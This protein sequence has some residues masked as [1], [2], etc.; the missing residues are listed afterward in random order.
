MATVT[1]VLRKDRMNKN[2]EAPLNFYIIRHRKLSKISTGIKIEPRYWDDKHKMVKPGAAN[3]VRLNRSIAFSY[4]KLCDE[5]LDQEKNSRSHS[6]K[7]LKEVVHGKAPHDFF[8]FAD[9]VCDKYLTNKMIGTYDKS[10]SIIRKIKTYH[11]RSVLNFEDMN[12]EWLTTYDKYLKVELKNKINTVHKDMKF[13]RKV[14]SDA[15]L[16]DIIVHNRNPFLKYKLKKEKTHR[17]YLTEAERNTLSELILNTGTRMELHRDMFIFAAWTCGVRIS[18]VLTLKWSNYDG[19]HI[20]FAMRKTKDQLSIKIPRKSIEIL[21]KYKSE[22]AR[23]ENFIFP[24]LPNGLDMD[25]AKLVDLEISRA[26]AYINKN[27]KLIAEKAELQKHLSFHVSRHTWATIALRKGMRIEKVSKLLG[28]ASIKETMIYAK[29]V[30]E[31]LD[32]AMD[33]LDELE[34]TQ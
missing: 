5:V 7:K 22:N 32:Q 16:E 27:L 2:G 11:K 26:T 3:S 30:N 10:R 34:V 31:E 1:K 33:D 19:V 8:S 6:P 25:N 18:D 12:Y 29:I 21:S 28:H 4:S 20:N 9:T 17:E 13:I 24:L 14:F 15:Y 23:P